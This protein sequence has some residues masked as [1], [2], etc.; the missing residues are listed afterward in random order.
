MRAI[1]R[2]PSRTIHVIAVV[3][4]SVETDAHLELPVETQNRLNLTLREPKKDSLE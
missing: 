2:M 4:L 1:V 3:A